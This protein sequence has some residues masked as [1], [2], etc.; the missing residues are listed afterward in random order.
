[1]SYPLPDFPYG[2]RDFSAGYLDTPEPDTLPPGATPDAANGELGSVQVGGQM[3]AT[4]KKRRGH[5]LVTPGAMVA[6]VPVDGLKEFTRAGQPNTLVAACDGAVWTFDNVNACAQVG[7]T[8]PFTAGN[9]VRFCTFKQQ[10]YLVDGTANQRY[11][12]TALFAVGFAAPTGV[13][14]MTAVSPTG[15]GLTGTYAAIYV[16]YDS[17]TGHESSPTSTTATVTV[18]N[19]ARRHTKPSG[20]PASNVTHWR[21]YVRRTDTNEIKYYRVASVAVATA[22]YDEQ[23]IDTARVDPA[24]E[25]SSN[26]VAPAFALLAEFNGTG[27][28]VVVND[29]Q[30]YAS[31]QGD[32]ES[33]HPRD[34]LA[35]ARGGGE[36]I[37][38]LVAF[39]EDFLVMKPHSTHR[40]DGDKMPFA[41]RQVHPAFG[42]VSQEAAVEVH[43]RLYAWDRVK[44][45]YVTDTVTWTAL[46]DYRIRTVVNRVNRTGLSGIRCVHDEINSLVVWAVPT[47]STRRRTLLA[48]H[49]GLDAW[50]PPWTGLEYASLATFT[51]PVSGALGTY[52][53]DYWGRLFELASGAT[54][55][56]P[57]GGTHTATVTSATSGT[58]VCAGATFATTGTGLAGLPV[59]VRSPAGVWQWRRLAGNTT[60]TLV[61]DTTHD[62]IWT[63]M[64]EA[65]WTVIVGGIQWFHHT[66]WI[67]LSKPDVEK[68]LQYFMLQGKTVSATDAIQ[69]S[70]RYDDQEGFA[71]ADTF[72]LPA[73]GAGVWGVGVWGVSLW[74]GSS[75]RQMRKVRVDRTV[76][77]AQFRFENYYPDQ[78]VEITAYQ[79]T[80]DLLDRR[81]VPSTGA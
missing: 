60:D 46:A 71:S 38:C 77:S 57:T 21:A 12:G 17:A 61:L 24:P 64:P 34:V 29:D 26:D 6:G 41:V 43:D 74:G 19:Q 23:V 14:D 62:A 1:M 70:G 28:G 79:V 36:P 32:L 58:V 49:Y 48:Y 11:N 5:R 59:A 33:W 8:A 50:L 56:I 69:V 76:L 68:R 78:P 3:R 9:A 30:V 4:L 51:N 15:T 25:P 13:T 18:S 39:G 65:G 75:L 35:V 80:G 22:T 42:C 72:T 10:L 55:G 63:H 27:I 54:D 20:T 52:M 2:T 53:G 7:T 45:P 31:K 66:P 73:T 16:W 40:L 81:R 44:G 67:D 47:T 37:T